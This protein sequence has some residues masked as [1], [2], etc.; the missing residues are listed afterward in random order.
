MAISVHRDV[1]WPRTRA[2]RGMATS[3]AV[4]DRAGRGGEGGA[5]PGVG[6]KHPEQVDRDCCAGK[7]KRAGCR[8]RLSESPVPRRMEARR[9]QVPPLK[10]RPI[11]LW[12]PYRILFI[13]RLRSLCVQ[14]AHWEHY[15]SYQA[16]LPSHIVTYSRFFVSGLRSVIHRFPSIYFVDERQRC[17]SLPDRRTG[18]R[19]RRLGQPPSSLLAAPFCVSVSRHLAGGCLTLTGRPLPPPR[20]RLSAPHRPP[21]CVSVSH[22]TCVSLSSGLAGGWWPLTG[23][24]PRLS[25][26]RGLGDSYLLGPDRPPGLRGPLS[27]ARRRRPDRDGARGAATAPAVAWVATGCSPFARWQ[28]HLQS[29]ARL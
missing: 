13:F 25:L 14:N 22:P 21:T 2:A 27:P 4:R 23:G 12:H 28:R 24:L 15:S 26:S 18:C 5:A 16:G 9:K 19:C 29:A 7:E 8:R 20:R 1:R 10:L 3:T 17:R 6:P 11:C